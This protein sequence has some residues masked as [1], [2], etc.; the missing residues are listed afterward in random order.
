MRYI[1]TTDG[2]LCTD[3]SQ[4]RVGYLFITL[5]H[6]CANLFEQH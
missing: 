2:A 5:F 3:I 4:G 1:F 6:N